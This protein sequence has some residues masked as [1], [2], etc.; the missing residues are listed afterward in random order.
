MLASYHR[1][2]RPDVFDAAVAASAP[3]YYI[4]KCSACQHGSLC[5]KFETVLGSKSKAYTH[6]ATLGTTLVCLR[7][8]SPEVFC[9]LQLH[10][11]LLWCAPVTQTL[12][13]CV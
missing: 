12:T 1:V 5:S 6:A 2:V 4:G 9:V 10:M 8:T 3:I 13:I 11:L 7:E